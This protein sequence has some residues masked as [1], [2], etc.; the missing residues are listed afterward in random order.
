MKGSFIKSSR[1][2]K[3]LPPKLLEK[4]QNSPLEPHKTDYAENTI[5]WPNL[6]TPKPVLQQ[7]IQPKKM[8]NI[9]KI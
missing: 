2:L 1:N 6:Y 9:K 3:K 4:L 8:Y 5:K 7:Q